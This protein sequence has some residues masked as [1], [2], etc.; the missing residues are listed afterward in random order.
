MAFST[1]PASGL[2]GGGT[3]S[4]A[5]GGDLS[6]VYPNPTVNAIEGIDVSAVDPTVGQVLTATSSSAANWQTPS[7]GGSPGGGDGNVQYNNGGSFGG[8][9]SLFYD[10]T[11]NRLGIGTAIPSTAL[12]LSTA[13]GTNGSTITITHTGDSA[14]LAIQGSNPAY[15]GQ[16]GAGKA[17][18]VF[19]ANG[20]GGAYNSSSFFTLVGNASDGAANFMSINDMEMK[21][22][23]RRGLTFQDS[24]R[25]GTAVLVGGTVTVSTTTVTGSSKIFLTSQTDGGVPGFLRIT[26]ISAGTSFTITSSN[27]LDTSTVAYFILEKTSSD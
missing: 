14:G 4:G 17:L 20:A 2:P 9:S 16:T 23:G 12:E 6:G 22:S 10:D 25:L 18:V 5:A 7:S 27:A 15:M 1:G 11:N 21:F 26:A 3:P 19:A 13:S 24:S 8:E